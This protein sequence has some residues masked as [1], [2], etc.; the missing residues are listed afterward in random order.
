MELKSIGKG[1]TFSPACLHKLSKSILRRN[2][3]ETNFL[4]FTAK[5]AF[6]SQAI[7]L[8]KQLGIALKPRHDLAY[9][10]L[11]LPSFPRCLDR[12]S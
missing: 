3:L 4:R 12:S 1:L 6:V 11:S 7:R 9:L 10:S 2:T 8:V 5:K